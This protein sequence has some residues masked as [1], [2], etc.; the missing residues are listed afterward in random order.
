MRVSRVMSAAWRRAGAWV[1]VRVLNTSAQGLLIETDAVVPIGTPLELVVDVEGVD[2]PLVAIA[3]YCGATRWGHGV[4]AS[5]Q[6]I[7][8]AD[9]ERWIA[10]YRTA[11]RH[12]ID[13]LPSSLARHLIE[14]TQEVPLPSGDHLVAHEPSVR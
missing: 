14:R 13:T 9:Q 3:R 8:R 1:P 4:G 7:T 12:K 2:V 6:A 11:A 10:S 5:V